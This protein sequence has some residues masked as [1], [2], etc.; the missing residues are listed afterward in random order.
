MQQYQL[1][2]LEFDDAGISILGFE[3]D[4][5]SM[6]SVGLLLDILQMLIKY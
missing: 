2:L 5:L 6:Q 1:L 3:N 4:N